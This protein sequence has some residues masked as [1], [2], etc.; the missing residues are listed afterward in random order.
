MQ[1]SIQTLPAD[2]DSRAVGSADA[3]AGTEA[4][5]EAV[6]ARAV[7]GRAMAVVA[8]HVDG[9]DGMCRECLEAWARLAPF[10]CEQR[11]WAVAVIERYAGPP[12]S[13]T[14]ATAAP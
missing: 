12:S 14:T 5:S 7:L 1:V 2:T 11:R 8:T 3:E 9:G 6:A 10:P 4:G 13:P